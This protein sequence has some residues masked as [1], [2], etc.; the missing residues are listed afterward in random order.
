MILYK[1]YELQ[2]EWRVNVK[3]FVRMYKLSYEVSQIWQ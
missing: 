1:P 2:I 3:R